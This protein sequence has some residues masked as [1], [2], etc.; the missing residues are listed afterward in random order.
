MNFKRQI[1]LIL[2]ILVPSCI[3]TLNAQHTGRF[4]LDLSGN[5]WKLWL[6]TNAH[7]IN[8]KLFAPPVEVKNLPVNIP[9]G[10]WQALDK[11]AGKTVHLPATVEEFYWG[12][13]G[14]SLGVA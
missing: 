6:D 7:W 4:E 3:L 13:N 9:T 11:A 12:S 2:F 1:S 10:G 8:D 5:N 14:N